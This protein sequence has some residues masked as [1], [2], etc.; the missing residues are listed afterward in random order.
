M[1]KTHSNKR[2][3]FF[4]QHRQNQRKLYPFSFIYVI[5]TFDHHVPEM[6]ASRKNQ[7]FSEVFVGQKHI[8]LLGTATID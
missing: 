7:I 4:H 2:C 5:E 1:K 6:Y 3:N 8:S